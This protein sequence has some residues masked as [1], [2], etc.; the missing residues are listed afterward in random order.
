MA[1]SIS[2]IC[3]AL[4]YNCSDFFSKCGWSGMED[5]RRKGKGFQ[6]RDKTEERRKEEKSG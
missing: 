3:A 5:E 4:T 2:Y 6:V 1:P